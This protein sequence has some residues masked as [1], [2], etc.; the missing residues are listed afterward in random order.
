ME[1]SMLLGITLCINCWYSPLIFKITL[2]TYNNYWYVVAK[3]DFELFYPRGHSFERVS[4]GYVID[5]NCTSSSSVVDGVEAVILF[6]ASCVPYRE[7][8]YSLTLPIRRIDPYKLLHTRS[9]Y[10]W[11]LLLVKIV[12]GKPYSEWSLAYSRFSKHDYF[13]CCSWSFHYDLLLFSFN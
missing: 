4:I 10:C 9:I 8:V 6:L 12:F 13:K 11:F 1:Y 2:I 5:Y 3:L 7:S